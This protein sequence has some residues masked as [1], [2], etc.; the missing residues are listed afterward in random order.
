MPGPHP[1]PVV[2]DIDGW[3]MID[4][5]SVW[6]CT[7]CEF[8]T[9]L[10]VPGCYREVWARAMDR[11]LTAIQESEGGIQLSLDRGDVLAKLARA[12]YLRESI[13]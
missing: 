6:Q 11:V 10:D 7:L 4:K 12:L 9:M 3:N 2:E 5:L 13:L 1:G 8:P